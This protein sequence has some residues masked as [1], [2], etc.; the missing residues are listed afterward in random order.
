[1]R[2]LCT[3]MRLVGRIPPA[4]VI[5]ARGLPPRIPDTLT[6]GGP[7][8]APFAWLARCA[9]S[10]SRGDVFDIA[11][12]HHLAEEVED[13]GV[14]R[15]VAAAPGDDGALERRAVVGPPPLLGHVGAVDGEARDD[16]FQHVS[17]EERRVGEEGRYWRE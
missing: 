4:P 9:R 12:Q 13:P 7:G 2:A 6:R 10:L 3:V 11:R 5:F 16:F 1:R 17:S 15:R 14:P 8:P